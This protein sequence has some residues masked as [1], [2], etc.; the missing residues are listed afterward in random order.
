MAVLSA[1]FVRGFGVPYIEAMA[2]GTAVVATRIRGAGG[3]RGGRYG[4]IVRDEELGASLCRLIDDAA[5]RQRYAEVRVRR[6]RDFDWNA[7]CSAYENVY[8]RALADRSTFIS[9]A[10]HLKRWFPR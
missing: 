3:A 9:R 7:I 2:S 5:L 10:F 1:E 6:A 4:E 8:G